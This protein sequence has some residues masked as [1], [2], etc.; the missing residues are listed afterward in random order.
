MLLELEAED[1]RPP[2]CPWSVLDTCLE[3]TALHANTDETL[4]ATGPGKETWVK[5]SVVQERCERLEPPIRHGSAW[6]HPISLLPRLRPAPST[7]LNPYPSHAAIARDAPG[8]RWERPVTP[9]CQPSNPLVRRIWAVAQEEGGAR[10][11]KCPSSGPRGTE[12]ER[13]ICRVADWIFG[14]FH[15]K[16]V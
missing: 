11:N 1:V 14:S 9:G 6:P 3:E 13:T 4:H 16:S 8:V 10:R 12:M 5:K 15:D 2:S 7:M